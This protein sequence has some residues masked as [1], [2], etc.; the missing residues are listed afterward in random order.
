MAVGNFHQFVPLL[1]H[2]K[3]KIVYLCGTVISFSI[4]WNIIGGK[5]DM[6]HSVGWRCIGKFPGNRIGRTLNSEC[7]DIKILSV[8]CCFFCF[9]A[10]VKLFS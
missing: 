2:R 4:L 9:F 1:F 7:K 3:S 8:F 10:S 6:L 5:S